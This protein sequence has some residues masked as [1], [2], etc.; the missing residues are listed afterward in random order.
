MWK[1]MTMA[2]RMMPLKEFNWLWQ[3][4][5]AQVKIWILETQILIQRPRAAMPQQMNNLKSRHQ[6]NRR[7]V[8][9]LKSL[10]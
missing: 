7:S 8:T 3:M 9:N 1:K 4:R 10:N 2:K 6:R 5:V